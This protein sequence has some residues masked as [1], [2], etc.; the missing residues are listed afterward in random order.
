MSHIEQTANFH[1]DDNSNDSSNFVE[2][3]QTVE[4]PEHSA[5]YLVGEYTDDNKPFICQFCDRAFLSRSGRD[6]H[7]QLKHRVP[8]DFVDQKELDSHELELELQTGELIKGWKCPFCSFI[9]RRKNHHQT[10]LMR[11]AI[12]DKFTFKQEKPVE[13]PCVTITQTGSIYDEDSQKLV[14]KV[15]ITDPKDEN[16]TRNHP[17]PASNVPVVREK[18]SRDYKCF[19]EDDGICFTCS[20]CRSQFSD[21]KLAVSHV[22]RLGK[23][24]FCTSVACVECCVAFPTE[25]LYQRHRGYHSLAPIAKFLNY[26]ECKTCKVIF[27]TKIELDHHLDLHKEF[28]DSY[29][30]QPEST[31]LFEGYELLV[32]DLSAKPHPND[33]RCGSCRK[34]GSRNEINLHISIFHA[35]LVCPFDNQNFSRGVGYFVDHMKTKHPEKFGTTGVSFACPHCSEEFPYKASMLEHCSVC[36]AKSFS[37]H[38][39]EKKYVN[40]RQLKQ[41]LALVKGI[42]N[43]KCIICSKFFANVSDLKLHGRSHTNDRPYRCTF[44]G[45]QKKFRVNSHL[46]AHMD[47]HNTHKNYKCPS[48][49]KMFQTRGARRIH[50]RT[51]AA[52]LSKCEICHKTFKQRSHYV[53]HVNDIHHITCRSYNLEEAIHNSTK[54]CVIKEHSSID[55]QICDVTM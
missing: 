22:Q 8:E 11:H 25:K 10:H 44:P 9:S 7:Q 36:Q 45:C 24:G 37:C 19:I 40:E 42:K 17:S 18:V 48:C 35:I 20:G 32:K 41:H 3:Q 1:R 27:S 53:R 47:T 5:D 49:N 23:N 54:L 55:D 46:S 33:F 34:F 51:H 50:Q 15:E 16:V 13:D 43:H 4:S 52:V 38:H 39:C 29:Q 12:R 28:S 6:T 31:A 26:F 30:Y 21:V 14:P 2:E